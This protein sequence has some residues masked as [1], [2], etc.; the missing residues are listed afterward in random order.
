MVERL[1]CLEIYLYEVEGLCQH[2]QLG[3]PGS[4][5]LERSAFAH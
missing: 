5:Q 3:F 4:M 1:E 2:E